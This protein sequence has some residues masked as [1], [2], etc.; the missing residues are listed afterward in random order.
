MH[1]LSEVSHKLKIKKLIQFTLNI[2]FF[3]MLIQKISGDRHLA[4][5]TNKE[6]E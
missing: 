5:L 6:S 4:C 2:Y 1:Y 3:S